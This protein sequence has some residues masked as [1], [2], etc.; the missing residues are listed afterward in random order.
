MQLRPRDGTGRAVTANDGKLRSFAKILDQDESDELTYGNVTGGTIYKMMTGPNGY[1]KF[2]EFKNDND[3][4][5]K[6]PKLRNIYKVIK[7]LVEACVIGPSPG[8]FSPTGKNTWDFGKISKIKNFYVGQN[9]I[10]AKDFNKIMKEFKLIVKA[11]PNENSTDYSD[12]KEFVDEAIA[13]YR[14]MHPKRPI[15]LDDVEY[16]KYINKVLK[17]VRSNYLKRETDFKIVNMSDGSISKF[18]AGGLNKSP[19]VYSAYSADDTIVIDSKGVVGLLLGDVGGTLTKGQV[20][21]ANYATAYNDLPKL[22]AGVNT[23]NIISVDNKKLELTDM[24]DKTKPTDRFKAMD[25]LFGDSSSAVDLKELLEEMFTQFV[26]RTTKII[27]KDPTVSYVFTDGGRKH[28]SGGA[29]KPAHHSR[30]H[31]GARSGHKK[32]AGRSRK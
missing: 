8:A 2:N 32:R 26:K 16:K 24:G 14:K 13:T 7:D 11:E 23:Q 29:R 6:V 28:R 20:I 21:M 17:R 5:K 9:M 4:N 27:N 25:I 18:T 31:D 12:V 19:S 22:I 10:D 30:R 3:V 1:V 15:K